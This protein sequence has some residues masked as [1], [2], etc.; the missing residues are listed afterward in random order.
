MFKQLDLYKE[1]KLCPNDCE[2]DR[3]AGNKG[4]CRMNSTL[5][6]A[7][8]GLHMWEEPPLSGEWGSGTVFFSGC[9]L[10]CV[11]CQ[12]R[13]VSGGKA[14]E[15]I[16]IEQ[17]VSIFLRLQELG[18]HNI[19]LVTA[20]HYIPHLLIALPEAKR[21]GLSLPIVYNSSG[22]E[23]AEAL[24][25]LDGLIDIYL[26]DF[27]YWSDSTA[28]RYSG[29][30]KYVEP[31]KNAI[32]EMVRQ[33]GP[34]KFSSDG[35]MRSGIICRH[36]LLPGRL[37]EACQIM[38]YLHATYG[39]AIYLSLMSQFTPFNIPDSCNEINRKIDM[40]DYEK[41]VDFCVDKDII[42]AFVQEGEA[43]SES[44]IPDFYSWH[45]KDFLK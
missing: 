15:E 28:A 40:A 26:P 30:S 27:K 34:C 29:I 12:N 6:V 23:S 42:N 13:P 21:Q 5:K 31:T 32:A 14:G 35:I 1:C 10:R 4:R 24:K 33:V 18:A 16:T 41:W 25:L 43:A 17:L 39:D 19:N 45:V 22:Y 38:N 8:A 9:P 3:L 20:V 36:L 37:D 44:F 2:I 7:R 11:F